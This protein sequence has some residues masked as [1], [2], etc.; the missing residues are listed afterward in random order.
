[1]RLGFVGCGTIAS[2]M[3][4]GLCSTRSAGSITL[5]PRNAKVA[6]GLASQFANVQ[7]APT[8][9]AVLDACEVVVLAVRPQIAFGVLSELRFRPDHHV[10]SLIATLPLEYIR[11]VTSPATLVTRAVPLPSVALRQGPT[12][13]YP[14][15]QP[16]KALFDALGTAIELDDESKF[17]AFA[18]ATAIMASYFSF[19]STVS[20]W[21][22]RNG[23]APENA[24]SY[25][26][27]MLRG[28]AATSLAMPDRSFNTLADEH[29]TPGG[30][31]E[32]VLRLITRDGSFVELDRALDAVLK[33][34]QAG[35]SEWPPKS[36]TK[37]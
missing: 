18:A 34:L 27:E 26:G 20:G 5:S 2:S 21:M 32:Q 6:A 31:N 1:M 16:I 11:S 13:I 9:Q 24:R 37:R 25:V 35:A 22:T 15:G 36:A 4:T 17:D 3:V 30:L 28:M 7:I 10:V 19:A 12:A 33:R 14:P 23:V 29:Q 8:N